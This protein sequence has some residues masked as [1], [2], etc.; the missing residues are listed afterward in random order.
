VWG[1]ARAACGP[2]CRA[3]PSGGDAHVRAPEPDAPAL[4]PLRAAR[5]PSRRSYPASATVNERAA[6]SGVSWALVP[7]RRAGLPPVAD[8]PVARC[9]P[10]RGTARRLRSASVRDARR[11]PRECGV[12]MW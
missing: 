10:H 8:W 6:S 3:T 11:T 4:G 7:V 12:T 5:R 2:R 9:V 1:R